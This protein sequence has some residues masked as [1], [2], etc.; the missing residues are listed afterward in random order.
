MRPLRICR[1]ELWRYTLPLVRPIFATHDVLEERRGLILE[2]E[3]TT[4]EVGVGEAAPF[5]GLSKES[6]DQVERA[7]LDL[8]DDGSRLFDTGF[9]DLMSLGAF[10]DA[11]ELPASAAHALDQAVLE[12]LARRRQITPARLL[13]PVA[14]AE[15][16]VHALV[17]GAE[18]AVLAVERG[19]VRLKMKVG[20]SEVS[21][22]EARVRDLRRAV[23]PEIAIRLD[24]NGAWSP[25][26][27]IAAIERFAQ[28]DIDSVEQ[29]VPAGDVIGLQTVKRAVS[30]PIAADESVRT[31]AD[32]DLIVSFGAADAVVIK[33]MLAGGVLAA[34][35]LASAA[36]DAGLA[37]SVTT[38]I[39]SAIGRAAARD[40][41]A[42]CPGILWSCGLD[43]GRLLKSDLSRG[44]LGAASN[45]RR[46]PTAD[47]ATRSEGAAIASG[48]GIVLPFRAPS[49]VGRH[50]SCGPT[51]SRTRR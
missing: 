17:L 21:E 30:V 44:R 39:E 11:V 36:A 15:V 18:D 43:T 12:M 31:R 29:P 25:S 33:P 41:A 38:S 35:A 37:V 34:H 1:A 9:E 22:D 5:P 32:L 13:H 49:E 45:V 7:L 24:A 2:L 14:R 47:R 8:A 42:A 16:P 6:L 3:S 50:P 10:L 51:R 20:W 27:A 28:H 19:F 4:G 46:I 23:G 40:V 48:G 26:Q